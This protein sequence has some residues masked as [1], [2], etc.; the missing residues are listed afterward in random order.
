MAFETGTFAD[1]TNG[2]EKIRDFCVNQAGWSLNNYSDDAEW[3]GKRLHIQKGTNYV[4]IISCTAQ[5]IFG[6]G[7]FTGVGMNSSTSFDI[8]EWST[9]Q[10]G[11]TQNETSADGVVASCNQAINYY[12]F[13]N[14]DNLTFV[15][16][17]ESSK[18]RYITFGKTSKG[19]DIL[20]GSHQGNYVI[21]IYFTCFG[22]IDAIKKTTFVKNTTWFSGENIGLSGVG[23][24][25]GIN[26]I[27]FNSYLIATQ[28]NDFNGLP[29]LLSN[30]IFTLESGIYHPQGDV[31]HFKILN[32]R[33]FDPGQDYIVGSN[34]Y[35]IFPS[36]YK[37]DSNTGFAVLK[38]V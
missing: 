17:F 15:I 22:Q 29:L 32:M 25:S 28:P 2:M 1:L 20:S 16:E 10:P 13:S 6:G 23:W 33:Y 7:S 19:N 38:V 26:T 11:C 34:T 35:T 9:N 5:A 37:P 8:G 31:E 14:D 24:L 4:N 27:G 21:P 30:Y 18:Y 3:G 36:H 12:F